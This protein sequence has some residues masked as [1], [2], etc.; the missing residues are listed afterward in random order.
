MNG[1]PAIGSIE[2]VFPPGCAQKAGSTV[3][4]GEIVLSAYVIVTCTSERSAVVTVGFSQG[5]GTVKTIVKVSVG[6]F[7]PAETS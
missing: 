2:M 1:R 4:S 7:C 3:K 5:S 6:P